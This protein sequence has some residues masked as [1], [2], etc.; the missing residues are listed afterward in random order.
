MKRYLSILLLLVSVSGMGVA[1]H[2]QIAAIDIGAP[3]SPHA[4]VKHARSA[5]MSPVSS[6]RMQPVFD[7]SQAAGEVVVLPAILANA[8]RTHRTADLLTFEGSFIKDLVRLNWTVRPQASIL[9][10]S[11]ERRSQSDAQ[12]TTIRYL[13][14]STREN[15]HGYSMFDH[16]GVDGVT[17]YRLRQIGNDGSTTPTPAISIMPHLVP[18]SFVIWQHNVDPFTRYGTLSFGLG[19]DM[20]VSIS[21]I[22][23]YGRTVASIVNDVSL[24]SGHHLIPFNTR[25]LPSGIYTLR[26]ESAGGVQSRR[27]AIL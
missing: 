26:M 3:E 10:F 15:T 21:M 17:F 14:A 19:S 1:Q 4:N 20:A 22:D 16:A 6:H 7:F 27:L 8:G 25:D 13:R 11:I 23:R 5:V 24:A 2:A 18:N 12:W 9:G